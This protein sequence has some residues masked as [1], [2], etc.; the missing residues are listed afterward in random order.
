MIWLRAALT[1]VLLVLANLTFGESTACR[2]GHAFADATL[3]SV[4]PQQ[5]IHDLKLASP[6]QLEHARVIQQNIFA[7]PSNWLYL[8]LNQWHTPTRRS[9]ILSTLPFSQGDWV[10]VSMLTEAERLLR[11]RPFFY[12]ARILIKRTCA[13]T[14]DI[15]IVVREVW[16]LT[17]ALSAS[18]EGGESDYQIGVADSNWQG[19]G[20]DLSFVIARDAEETEFGLRF[21]DHDRP[22]RW[23]RSL[24]S[25]VGPDA[26][27]YA[28]AVEKPFLT[29][30]TTSARGFRAASTKTLKKLYLLGREV[31]RFNT[32]SR[33]TD[34]FAARAWFDPPHSDRI[35]RFYVGFRYEQESGE[36]VWLD[37]SPIFERYNRV[38]LYPYIAW[39]SASNRFSKLKHFHHLGRDED[40]STGW[41]TF[42]RLGYTSRSVI[43]NATTL[44]VEAL[45]SRNWLLNDTH[46]AT[47]VLSARGHYSLPDFTPDNQI[48][49]LRAAY[50]HAFSPQTKFFASFDFSRGRNLDHAHFFELGGEQGLR[51]YSNH[52]Q[53]GTR[54]YRLL[55]EYRYES[56]IRPLNLFALGFVSFFEAGRA[57]FARTP[58]LWRDSGQDNILSNIGFGVRLHS[59]RTGS[60]QTIH[61]DLARPLRDP[62]KQSSYAL[63]VSVRKGI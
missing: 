29:A 3:H 58:A 27:R 56:R 24:I 41:N 53:T 61:I 18:R 14:V 7:E 51:G 44:Q 59:I 49:S 45:L 26:Y 57:W 39:E 22:N 1:P 34:V 6:L 25:Q 52:F 42:M 46:V 4:D 35:N 63:S 13:T 11:S 17:P 15:D 36:T 8:K 40:I 5:L 37:D 20:R 16:T 32:T 12:D 43:S 2:A 33:M 21:K 31:T 62:G 38:L 23:L 10:D 19:T 50:L 60:S 47:A 48:V 9:T 30:N 54:M 55:M 28:L